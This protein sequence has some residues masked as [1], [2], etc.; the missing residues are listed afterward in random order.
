MIFY[1][2]AYIP[3]DPSQETCVHRYS[4][5]LFEQLV[6]P[7]FPELDESRT[8]F[9]IQEFI[10]NVLPEGSICGPVASIEFKSRF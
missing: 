2:V 3:P 5:Y 8:N 1:F 6:R 10:E 4:I 9:H 7:N